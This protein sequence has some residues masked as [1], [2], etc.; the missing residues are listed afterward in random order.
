MGLPQALLLV[1]A[2]AGSSSG[3]VIIPTCG[4]L[5][6]PACTLWDGLYWTNLTGACD[7]GLASS[8]GTCVMGNKRQSLPYDQSWVVWAMN[9]QQRYG[10]GADANI[11]QI[12]TVGTHNSYSS[13]LQ[14]C[15]NT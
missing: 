11:D 15:L 13:Y 3:Q 5:N 9:N 12:L 1:I 6:G 4:Y 8:N 10:I 14:G 2:M 7:W